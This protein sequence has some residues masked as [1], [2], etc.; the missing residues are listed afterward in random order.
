LT[1]RLGVRMPQRVRFA[2]LREDPSAEAE[3]IRR[4]NARSV[5]LAAGGGCTA[6]NLKRQFPALE[7]VAFDSDRTQVEHVRAKIDAA[8]R[9]DG[10]ALSVGDASPAR[11]NQR[12][13]LEGLFRVFRHFLLEFVLRED[14]LETFFL[15][16]TTANVRENLARDWCRS[17]FWPAAFDAA[18][19]RAHLEQVCGAPANRIAVSEN[20]FRRAIERGLRHT[21]SGRSA[22]LQH[23]FLGCYYSDDAPIYAR[24][25][26]PLP[27]KLVVGDL[28]DVKDLK[29]F[30]L[31]SLS[32][33]FDW[34]DD[35]LVE[36]WTSVLAREM[37][38]GATVLIRSLAAESP[39]FA[40]PAFTLDTELGRSLAERDR[41]FFVERFDVATRR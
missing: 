11:L 14:E 29:R 37:K 31:I 12:G 22:A 39:A 20:H 2:V 30:D 28:P 1:P 27:V 9:G 40:D 24:T 23:I 10:Y 4:T 6:L 19:S 41:S 35:S 34:S 3:L 21:E 33:V 36:R 25:S 16:E 17:S 13:L 8:F 7:V 26:G 5:L 38:P 32:N 15:P 18:F